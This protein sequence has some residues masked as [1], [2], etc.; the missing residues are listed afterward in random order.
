MY[1]APV[2]VLQQI[3]GTGQISE[4][5]LGHRGR[6]SPKGVPFKI[7]SQTSIIQSVPKIATICWA[8]R[9][10]SRTDGAAEST[11]ECADKLG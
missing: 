5:N 1:K 4:C 3:T 2:P 7:R 8:W 11:I 10:Q 6:A 9:G